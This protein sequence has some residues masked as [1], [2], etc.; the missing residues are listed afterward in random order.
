[1][2]GSH[3][4]VPNKDGGW[5]VKKGGASRSSGHFDRKSDAEQ[6]GRQISRNQNTELFIHGKNGQIQRKDSHGNDSYPPKG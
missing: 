2:A 5:D 1:M 4:I 6:A 3:H